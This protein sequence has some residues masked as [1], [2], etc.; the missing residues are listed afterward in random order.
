LFAS[1]QAKFENATIVNYKETASNPFEVFF[2]PNPLQ[3]IPLNKATLKKYFNIS[4]RQRRA[5]DITQGIRI[6]IKTNAA[7]TA[8]LKNK[9]LI[10][11]KLLF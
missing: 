7:F 2:V 1:T 5:N 4:I 11:L 10:L 8:E 6:E 9:Q 3:N